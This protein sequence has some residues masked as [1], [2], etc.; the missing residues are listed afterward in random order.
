V[1]AENWNEREKAF[2]LL[3]RLQVAAATENFDF[4]TIFGAMESLVCAELL[5]S[6][7][8]LA[9]NGL[10]FQ[11]TEPNYSINSEQKILHSA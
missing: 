9:L 6:I 8:T 1:I 5:K 11:K 4:F 7:K 10:E 2:E 3:K